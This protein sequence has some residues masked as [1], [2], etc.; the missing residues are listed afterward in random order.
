[1]CNFLF[2]KFGSGT[3]PY[4]SLRK[5]IWRSFKGQMRSKKSQRRKSAFYSL[6]L[7]R[8]IFFLNQVDNLFNIITFLGKIINPLT[9]S[10]PKKG[11]SLL[12]DMRVVER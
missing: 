1:M 5:V 2:F 11:K 12:K 3:L 10:I 6:Y 9:I 4:W 8:L 7:H